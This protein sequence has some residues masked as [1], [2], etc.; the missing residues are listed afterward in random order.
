M[1]IRIGSG[2]PSTITPDRIQATL[3]L[4]KSHERLLKEGLDAG[5][6]SSWMETDRDGDFYE[7]FAALLAT[8]D[9]RDAYEAAR[10]RFEG[11]KARLTGRADFLLRL[12]DICRAE[13]FGSAPP[14]SDDQSDTSDLIERLAE[15]EAWGRIA[16]VVWVR[17]VQSGDAGALLETVNEHPETRNFLQPVLDGLLREGEELAPAAE[18][19]DGDEL[20]R[21]LRTSAQRLDASCLDERELRCIADC[22]DRLM[23]AAEADKLRESAIKLQRDQ[24]EAWRARQQPHSLDLPKVADKLAVL[25]DLIDREVLT[26]ADLDKIVGLLEQFVSVHVRHREARE[27]VERALREGLPLREA[28]NTADSIGGELEQ[29]VAAIND[30]FP[31]AK[32]VDQCGES[33]RPDGPDGSGAED[34]DTERVEGDEPAAERVAPDE[35]DS[36][37][38]RIDDS[39]PAAGTR[40]KDADGLGVDPGSAVVDTAEEALTV[41][42]TGAESGPLVE[43]DVEP[44]E[45]ARDSGGST[46]ADDDHDVPTTVDD[47][48]ATAINHGRLGLAYHLAS[49]SAEAL[50]SAD[51]VMLVACNYANDDLAR[52]GAEIHGVADRLLPETSLHDTG[53]GRTESRHFTV[54]AACAV[55]DPALVAPGGPAGQLLDELAP[56]LAHSPSL[57]SLAKAASDVSMTGVHLPRSLLRGDADDS[58]WQE[59][60][61]ALRSETASWLAGERRA[62]LR[63]RAATKLWRRLLEDWG[64][65]G[66]RASL[67]RI[68]HLV[69]PPADKIDTD[70]LVR[71]AEYWRANRDKEL[72]RI[73]R[74]LRGS[75]ALSK[76]EGSARTALRAKVDQALALADRW[77]SLIGERPAIQSP[78]HA[79]QARRLREAVDKHLSRALAETGGTAVEA[80]SAALLKRYGSLFDDAAEPTQSVGLTEILHGD[81]LANPDI[82]FDDEG[83]PAETPLPADALRSLLETPPDFAGAA[84]DRARRGDF[85][86]A[87]AAIR[88]A[89][90]TGRIDLEQADRARNSIDEHRERLQRTLAEQLQE[91]RV[92]LDAAYA[93]GSLTWDSYDERSGEIS[94]LD[95]ADGSFVRQLEILKEVDNAMDSAKSS[96]R[97]AI[98]RRVAGLTLSQDAKRRIDSVVDAGQLQIAEDF[99]ERLEQGEDLPA[100]EAQRDLPF[101]RFFPSFV[102]DFSVFEHR[103]EDG[104]GQVRQ[105]VGDRESN[106]LIDAGALSEDALRDGIALLDAWVALRDSPTSTRL[107]QPLMAALGFERAVVRGS[108]T[109]TAR[110]PSGQPVFELNAVPISDRDTA[111]LPDFGSRANGNYRLM[112]LRGRVTAE[113]VSQEVGEGPA[114][115]GLPNIV[116]FV[117]VL[118]VEARR[119]LARDFSSGDFHATLVL[120][121]ALVA[122]VSSWPGSRLAAFFDCASAFAYSQPYDPDAPAL[123]PEMFYGR[124]AARDAIV[125]TSGDLTHFVYGGRRLG[126]TTLL[127]DIAREYGARAGDEPEELVLFVNLKGSGIGENQPTE[128]LWVLFGRRLAEHEVLQTGTVRP[129]TIARG[130]KEW[131]DEAGGRRILLLVDESDA[132]LEAERRPEQGYRVLDRIKVLMEDT[133][134]RFKVV[135]A[136]LHN[137]Q[138]AAKDPNTPFA[139]LGEAVQIGPMLPGVD[140]DEIQ[141]LIRNP[142]EALGYRFVSNDSII[143]IVAETNY[144]PALAQQFCKELLKTM[145]EAADTSIEQ[146]PP[147]PI[148]PDMVDRVFNA[149]ETRNRVRNLFAWTIQ[150]DPRYEFLTYLIAQRS[151]DLEDGRPRSMRIADIREAALGEWSE[152]FAHDS[153]FWMFEVLLDEMVGLGIL[154]ESSD[155]F[156]IRTRNLRMLLGNDEE[157][158]RRLS[159]ASRRRAPPVFDPPEFRYTLDDETPSS[160]SADQEKR[161]F[162]RRHTV[163]LVFGTRLAGLDRVC[164]SIRKA[165]E[166]PDGS[167]LFSGDLTAPAEL[168]NTLRQ[169]SRRRRP[170]TEVVLV[171]MR[172]TWDEQAFGL[173]L[174]SVEGQEGQTR[175]V[176]PIFL[177]GPSVAWGRLSELRAV[178]GSA[179]REVWL[180]PCARDFT[181]IWLTVRESRA[182]ASFE[183]HGNSVDLPWPSTV[184]AAVKKKQLESIEQVVK[185][186]LED[187]SNDLDVSDILMS[188]DARIVFRILSD[189]GGDRVTADDLA[190][191]VQDEGANIS[192][193]DILRLCS[194]ADRLG[195]L[196]RTGK[197]YRLD[198]TYAMGLARALGG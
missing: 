66:G 164:E 30:Q 31:P 154:R 95:P 34:L 172:E 168:P 144:Y 75:E 188:E 12:V 57:R 38:P 143:R 48:I 137:V 81:L 157:I 33:S 185:A 116:V 56:R 177:C 127:A 196:L 115:G 40:S 1:P 27:D 117:G 62:N 53:S 37:A 77:V 90:R 93:N 101:D 69:D 9:G 190:G 28:A 187:D 100:V 160:L 74:E 10:S 149:R 121:E 158:E 87:A 78:F 45:D 142:L 113:A 88:F 134:R 14:T 32:P 175:V 145:R 128:D 67:G 133:Q 86:N 59:A 3:G 195:V 89:E 94:D 171:D 112:T 20:I 179:V 71:A 167:L 152:G 170:G 186:C 155:R 119:T 183:S 156:A 109:A 18:G 182:K 60:V 98:R 191:F 58:K 122:F 103:D 108:R 123:A 125:A 120:D 111:R 23:E 110:T 174:S 184:G 150:L 129:D 43:N 92:R 91:T 73:D 176:R 96:R 83:R 105:A 19:A 52:I 169:V 49:S 99:L 141:S 55:M 194:W 16:E 13:A 21:R 39:A 15:E 181:R 118:D 7:R 44:S 54:L 163:G 166:R 36:C 24:L 139:H 147:F 178:G 159:D 41:T 35:P 80:G 50:L 193:E 165:A 29:L 148:H 124:K 135:F 153:S 17:A 6:A 79:E 51:L 146:G 70:G 4:A 82:A 161:L 11:G 84:V 136:G 131:L 140:G 22:V 138:R 5:A 46:G 197:S 65:D 97:D 68:F 104:I 180:G 42:G 47:Q 173:A 8:P 72:D 2:L 107:L 198:T 162:S 64:S 151:F 76:I 26:S 114:T 192:V 189:L 63:Y 106:G 130:I 132:F 85:T 102:E 25:E 126:K 61:A